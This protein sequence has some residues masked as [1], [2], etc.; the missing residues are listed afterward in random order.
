MPKSEKNI[1]IL[2][3]DSLQQYAL[4]R[5][6]ESLGYRVVGC[7]ASAQ[8]ALKSLQALQDTP[9]DKPSLLLV[10]IRLRGPVDGIEFVASLPPELKV[11]HIFITAFNDEQHFARS[12]QT[13]PAGYI[14][15][16]FGK[17][18]L[19]YQI[20]LALRNQEN[21]IQLLEKN[22]LLD[23]FLSGS[24]DGII[25]IDK[26]GFSSGVKVLK[27]SSVSQGKLHCLVLRKSWIVPFLSCRRIKTVPCWR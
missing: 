17:L 23:S 22:A 20:R 9:A 12:I 7:T 3:D 25:L 1:F 24:K 14:L 2:E 13:N 11:P 8:E 4:K 27:A 18:A 26:E 15:K 19:D 16:P 21:E 5:T 10:D 6:L